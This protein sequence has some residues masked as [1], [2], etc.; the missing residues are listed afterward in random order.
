ML[1]LRHNII[2]ILKFKSV[3]QHKLLDKMVTQFNTTE[4]MHRK[5]DL[6]KKTVKFISKDKKIKK[7]TSI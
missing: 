3:Y 6:K 5:Q 7:I 1:M 4:I 2:Y